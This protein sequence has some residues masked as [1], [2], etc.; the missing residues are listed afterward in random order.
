[1][2]TRIILVFL[3]LT[4]PGVIIATDYY[5]S[6]SGDDLKNNGLS[7]STPWKTIA[8][9]NSVFSSLKAGDR[10]LFKSGDVFYGTL[11]ITRSGVSGFPI[12]IG[13]YGTGGKPVITGFT[14]LSGW[15]NEGGGIYSI[16]LKC[17]SSP[18]ILIIDGIQH[19]MGRYPNKEYLI[20]E[21]FTTNVSITDNEL[22]STPNW[23]GAHAVIRKNNWVLDRCLITNH[24]G[25]ILTYK[26]L[27]T[28]INSTSNYGYFIQNDLETLDIFGEWYYDGAKLFIYTGTLNPESHNIKISTIN[29]LVNNNQGYDNIIIENIYFNGAN[30]SAVNLSGADNFNIRYCDIYH[31]GENGIL[32][33][34]CIY[35]KADNNVIHNSNKAGI[36]C[37]GGN[38]ATIT[39]NNISNSGIIPGGTN[40]ATQNNG[41]FITQND[42]CLIQYNSI[43]SSG[44]NGIYFTGN[45]IRVKNNFINKSSLILNDCAGIYTTGKSFTGRIIEGNIV[46][47]SVGNTDGTAKSLSV[48]A[49]GIYLDA[50]SMDVEIINNTVAF[51]KRSGIFFHESH[52]NLCTGNICYNNKQQVRFQFSNNNP[53][54]KIRNILFNSNILFAKTPDYISIYAVSSLDDIPEFMIAD[55]NYYTRPLDDDEIFF[56][57]SPSTGS[58]YRSLDDWQ[59]FTTQDLNSAKSPV[60]L[61]DTA[62]IDFLYNP[63]KSIKTYTL[64]QPMIDVTGKKYHNSVT[65]NPYTSIILMVDQEPEIP[66]PLSYKSSVIQDSARNKIEIIFNVDLA[67]TSTPE[68]AFNVMVNGVN[69]GV[70]SVLISENR[71]IL[72]LETPVKFGESV[73]V[74]YT[75]PENNKL[76]SSKGSFAE[77]IKDQVVTNNIIDPAISNKPP[78]VDL[79]YVSNA[80]SGFVYELDAS[81]TKVSENDTLTFKW[82]VPSSVPVS[83]TTGSKIRFLAPVVKI[84]ETIVFTVS[85]SDGRLTSD[86]KVEVNI[87]PY[88]PELSTVKITETLASEYYQ[89][90]YPENAT[91]GNPTTRWSAE[92]NDQ[93]LIVNLP[94]PCKISHLQVAFSNEQSYGSYFDIYVSKDNITWEPVIMNGVSCVFSNN[95]QT[96]NFPQSENSTLYSYVKLVG[97]GNSSNDWNN[98]AELKIFGS[99]SETDSKSY[100]NSGEIALYPN[101][102][103]QLIKVL[104]QEPSSIS[105][106]LRIYNSSG[107][108]CIEEAL[109]PDTNF[110]QL[111]IALKP[112]IYIAKIVQAG[113]IIHTQKLIVV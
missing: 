88:R 22:L 112:G 55:N 66:V 27:G 108:L 80:F 40:T 96:F 64:A 73:T 48:Y 7:S 25:S 91:D 42:N 102:V 95:W 14:N 82:R 26:N 63:T 109:A 113:L 77:N 2:L 101:P 99:E 1:M 93:W 17:E 4:S 18:E 8:K 38:N 54:D 46:L 87:L 104:I 34:G 105:R 43:N 31:S 12:T 85:V 33:T 44:S 20:Y 51:C 29:N 6:S 92:G 13:S 74:S 71:I 28:A 76:E 61:K 65:L 83:G 94:V 110:F 53:N 106:S 89:S 21:S 98:I 60:T 50:P 103:S 35:F 70:T 5:I 52:D 59:L 81:G 15:I 84:P 100:Y 75:Q 58:K 9:V 72:T 56:T 10:I 97:H 62:N 32:A 30:K 36:Y 41:I 111:Q 57:Y 90:N 47:N 16:S 78:V 11:N 3:F 19:S 45:G 49:E 37:A 79:T 24:T 68:E 86:K 39:N 69:R 107:T 23:Q 67:V